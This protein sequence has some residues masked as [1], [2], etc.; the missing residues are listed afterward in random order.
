MIPINP[1]S[2]RIDMNLLEWCW[3]VANGSR[4]HGIGS[5]RCKMAQTLWKLVGSFLNETPRFQS[6]RDGSETPQIGH[7]GV[8][9]PRIV[10]KCNGLAPTQQ[11]G[12]EYGNWIGIWQRWTD[13]DE[14]VVCMAQPHFNGYALTTKSMSTFQPAGMRRL[15]II[16]A[17]F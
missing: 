1:I 17:G 16:A 3:N 10:P 15:Y 13:M 5:N 7:I 9:L 12:L 14:V 11:N 2:I 4:I 8:A 6:T